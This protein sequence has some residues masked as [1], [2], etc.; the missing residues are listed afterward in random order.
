[1]NL[2]V[3][4]ETLKH[5]EEF[6][7]KDLWKLRL[8]DEFLDMTQKGQSKKGTQDKLDFI[9]I[10]NFCSEKDSVKRIKRQATD[11]GKIFANHIS[12]YVVIYVKS[13]ICKGLSKLRN[14][15]TKKI[16]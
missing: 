12:I 15:T 11:L 5:L 13:N 2:N 7:E 16:Q 1:M 9:K 10:K 4:C 3:N 14:K 6:L 8:D